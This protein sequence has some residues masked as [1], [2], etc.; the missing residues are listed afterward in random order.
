MPE[1]VIKAGGDVGGE[2]GLLRIP[3]K[4]FAHRLG[5]VNDERNADDFGKQEVRMS[6]T[7]EFAVGVA[8]VGGK[9][10]NAVVVEAALAQEFD[11]FPEGG[12]HA[13]QLVH[14]DGL[15]AALNFGPL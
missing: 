11:E 15:A 12:I 3:D 4:M 2:G 10:N 9:N 14:T 13:A 6:P 5:Q 1:Q 8:V 7:T